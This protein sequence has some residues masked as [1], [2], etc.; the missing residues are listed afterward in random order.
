MRLTA[1]HVRKL[2]KLVEKHRCPVGPGSLHSYE[3]VVQEDWGSASYITGWR[4]RKCG[5]M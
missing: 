2:R 4:C 5:A 3:L 1:R